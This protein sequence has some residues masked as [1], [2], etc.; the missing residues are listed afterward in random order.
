M[1]SEPLDLTLRPATVVDL[2]AVAEVHLRAREA[3]HPQMPKG[4]HPPDE[5][6]TWIGGWDL[7]THEVWVAELATEVVG[8]LRL[9]AA[10]LDDLYVDPGHQGSGVGSA[11]LEVAQSVR[12]DGFCLWVFESNTPARDFYSRRGLV[13]LER[14]DGSGNEERAPDIRMAWPG[15]DPVRFLRGLVDDVDG[16][17]GELL[18]RRAALTRAIQRHKADT[19]RD[20]DRER[21][22]AVAMAQRAPLLGEERLAR[23]VHVVITESLD[24]ARE[25]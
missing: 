15:L 24:A 23:I 19:S 3:A 22:I 14:T 25:A 6:R 7:S 8:Y 9:T 4:V 20:P 18:A 2:A 11:L 21:E 17:L 10:W 13:E 1:P 12:P 5:V 16:E